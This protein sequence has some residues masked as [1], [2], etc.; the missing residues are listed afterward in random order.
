M[1]E[2]DMERQAPNVARMKML[3][4]TVV[5][6]VSGSKTLKRRYQ[7]SHPQTGSIIPVD[8]HY[9]IGSVVGP[10]RFPGYGWPVFQSVIS[11]R[12]QNAIAG[13]NG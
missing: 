12:D 2:K 13:A 9:I 4:A 8:T 10:H 5:P 11:R 3:G 7:R 1:G 6:A